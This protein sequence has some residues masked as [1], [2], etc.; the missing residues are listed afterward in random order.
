M[1]S[2][3]GWRSVLGMMVAVSGGA[4][5]NPFAGFAECGYQNITLDEGD[6]DVEAKSEALLG[7]H[8][9]TLTWTRTGTT[10]SLLVSIARSEDPITAE[11]DCD[12]NLDGFHVPLVGSVTSDDGL[13]A[14]EVQM[15]AQLDEQGELES[16]PP[17]I[18]G[19]VDFDTL[20]AAGVTPPEWISNF[21]PLLKIPLSVPGV[22]PQGGAISVEHGTFD[23]RMTTVLAEITFP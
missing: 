11:S 10:T 12:G 4:A 14:I 8:S 20:K 9:G 2:V 15:G 13:V 17:A 3:T 6:V 16:I 1:G 5:C 23:N 21:F 22:T 7:D 18:G 19:S